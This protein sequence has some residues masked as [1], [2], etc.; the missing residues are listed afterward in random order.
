MIMEYLKEKC[1]LNIFSHYII[2]NIKT[3][4]CEGRGGFIWNNGSIYE[5]WWLNGKRQGQGR[6][7]Y[8]DG[9]IIKC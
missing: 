5:G 1:N 8:S 4:E 3:E 9:T 6:E 7:L 2:R